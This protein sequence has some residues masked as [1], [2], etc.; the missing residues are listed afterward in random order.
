MPLLLLSVSALKGQDAWPAHAKT[1]YVGSPASD[2]TSGL[3]SAMYGGE[4]CLLY[5]TAVDDDRFDTPLGLEFAWIAPVTGDWSFRL[6]AGYELWEISS[7]Q[8]AELDDGKFFPLGASLLLWRPVSEGTAISV[9]AGL[10]YVFVDFADS[11]GDYEDALM[12]LIEAGLLL[13]P[14]PAVG[15]GMG[16]GYQIPISESEN[17]HGDEL[18][19]DAL[20][21][22]L[23][24]RF[25]L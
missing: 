18:T 22:R 17:D 16:I 6:S 21:L 7:A 4:V 5:Y 25:A 19:L 24:L 14:S 12:S 8:E 9:G 11:G 23:S 1:A 20:Q 2:R 13:S 15:V 3:G 10:R